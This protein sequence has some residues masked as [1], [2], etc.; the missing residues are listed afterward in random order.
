VPKAVPTTAITA[1]PVLDEPGHGHGAGSLGPILTTTA[2][3][4]PPPADAVSEGMASLLAR[5]RTT[6]FHAPSSGSPLAVPVPRQ[7][8]AGPVAAFATLANW[9]S[10]F[11]RRR[12]TDASASESSV[13]TQAGAGQQTD[14]QRILQQF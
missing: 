7:T 11:S 9:S 14:A 6:S 5:R 3:T 8:A 12:R 10:T 4:A 13:P 2:T 1:P